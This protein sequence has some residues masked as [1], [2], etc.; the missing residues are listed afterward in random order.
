M[1]R[2][3]PLGAAEAANSVRNNGKQGKTGTTQMRFLLPKRTFIPDTRS[4]EVL[5]PSRLYE[6]E[7]KIQRTLE[8]V[9][10]H[11][12][13]RESLPPSGAAGVS[14]AKGRIAPRLSAQGPQRLRGGSAP[15]LSP[16]QFSIPQE[17]SSTAPPFHME[18]WIAFPAEDIEAAPVLHAPIRT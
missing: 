11:E 3:S 5:A 12:A 10:W 7:N 16:E 13:V 14:L 15:P 17:T 9:V 8:T 18:G 2:S 1:W 6:S 4:C